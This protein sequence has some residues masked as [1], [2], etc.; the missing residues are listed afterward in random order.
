MSHFFFVIISVCFPAFTLY[1]FMLGN[2][3]RCDLL[4]SWSAEMTLLSLYLRLPCLFFLRRS[5]IKHTNRSSLARHLRI[6]SRMAVGERIFWLCFVDLK[7]I[8]RLMDLE[9]WR[10]TGEMWI[11][12]WSMVVTRIG[13]RPRPNGSWRKRKKGGK[14]IDFLAIL[15]WV[16]FLHCSLLFFFRWILLSTHFSPL[17]M[18]IIIFVF[19]FPYMH[20]TLH[21][22]TYAFTYI[23]DTPFF[24]FIILVTTIWFF[25]LFGLI[26]LLLVFGVVVKHIPWNHYSLIRRLWS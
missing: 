10:R 17:I 12:G 21:T 1:S 18:K 16:D 9:L 3:N 24:A 11:L 23:N 6:H 7:D 26:L 2:I 22:P 14:V 5:G 15:I 13:N 25:G 8:R 4:L 20:I 19:F